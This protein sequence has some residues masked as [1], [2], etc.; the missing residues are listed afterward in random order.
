[1]KKLSITWKKRVLFFQKLYPLPIV[2]VLQKGH[3]D[4]M[5]LR[6]EENVIIKLSNV[7]LVGCKK[8]ETNK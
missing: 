4:R 7:A 2:M 6:Q 5:V 8:C 3:Y 1:M